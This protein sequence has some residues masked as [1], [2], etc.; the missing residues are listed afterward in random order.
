MNGVILDASAF[1]AGVPFGSPDAYHT[2]PE[3]YDEV[4]HIKGRQDAVR[5]LVDAGRLVVVS[6]DGK[7]LERARAAAQGSGDLPSLS[8]PDLS[9]LALAAQTRQ[10]IITDD[11]SVSN[12]ARHMGL[13]ALP[14]MTGGIRTAGVWQYRCPACRARRPPGRAC[15]VCGSALRRRLVG[16][17]PRASPPGR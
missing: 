11:Y 7:S 4:S 8:G 17:K 15:R 13:D 3:V 6:A 9:I 10:A 16:K 2:T 5:A 1:Y 14:V 12:A